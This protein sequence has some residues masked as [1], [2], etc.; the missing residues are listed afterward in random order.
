[1][2]VR[3]LESI[4]RPHSVAIIG[5]TP[6]AGAVGRLI[7]DNVRGSGFTG[8]IYPVN[9]RGAAVDGHAGFASIAAVPEPPDLAVIATPAD[10]VPGLIAEI[11]A[12]G[13]RGVVVI[14]AGFGEG[15]TADGENRRR[16]M[17]EAARPHLLRIVGPNCFG[18]IAPH[19]R[20]NASF[21]AATPQA[22]GVAFVTQSGAM[23]AAVMD[24]ATPRG[25]GFSAVVSVGDMTDVDFGD[26]LDWLSV[27]PATSAIL[28]YVEAI[29]HPRKFMSAARAAARAKPVIVIKSGRHGAAAKAATSHTGALAG[30]DAVYDAAFARAGVLRVRTIQQLFD[31]LALLAV[32]GPPKGERLAVVTNGGGAGVLAMDDL[33]DA[34]G[35]P[36]VLATDTIARLDRV[37]PAIWSR[38]NPV[39]IIG[40]ADAGR[41]TAAIAATL[42][43]PNVDAVAV[44]FCPTAV[45][46]ALA[47]AQAVAAI[48]R[49]KPILTAWLGEASVQQARAAL[50]A[51]GLPTF[52][53]PGEAID[54]FTNLVR[55]RKRREALMEVPPA[56]AAVPPDR[57]AAARRLIDHAASGWLPPATCRDLLGLYGIPINPI[58][59]AVTPDEAAAIAARLGRPVALKVRSPDVVHKSDVGGVVLDLESG[60][61]VRTAAAAMRERVLRALPAARFDGFTVEAMVRRPRAI[62]LFLG[63][64]VDATFGPVIAFG[65]GGTAVEVIRDQALGLPP[66]NLPLARAM[67]AETQVGRLLKGYRAEPP[68]DLDA[69]AAALVAVSQLV[70]DLPTVVD[71]DVNPLLADS[72]G[73]VA[74]DARVKIGVGT[75]ARLVISPYP[76]ELEGTM[77]LRSGDDVFVRP[78][79]P[80]DE[81]LIEELVRSLTPEDARFRF[82][83]P[84]R[85]LGH[86]SAA[87]LSQ[88]DYD[89]E[90][91]LMAFP[92]GENT[93]WGVVRMH[94]DP[95]GERA[96]FALTVASARQGLGLG[97]ALL[98][99]LIA[100]AKARGIGELWGLVLRDNARML[101]L[102][103][104]LGFETRP[105]QN[106]ANAVVC[107]R[108]LT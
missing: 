94:A 7:F 11:G 17:L 43:D 70:I 87:R 86:A 92:A 107:A 91:A 69:L 100:L 36:A 52:A 89:R 28:L 74:V 4:L 27:D 37:L 95:D 5:A 25:I 60:D 68:A 97:Y 14:T 79:R 1:V 108:A 58:F 26:L 76:S 55:F 104:E 71:I 18:V 73:I 31:T 84:L 16:A 32:S 82:F 101:K 67:I 99:R 63:L 106:D 51:D 9:P 21:A 35:V 33:L 13:T 78:I 62:E 61:A 46:D 65:R 59:P 29:T 66:L 34:G 49:N 80:E 75:P 72:D 47:V 64:T 96:E 23:M 20:L 88:I 77:R 10:A 93:P 105:T 6:R 30:S 22:G 3:H 19:S 2:S 12:K 98:A 102:C 24:W 41:Y 85:G 90:I 50:T 39:D 103:G 81:P 15:G 42:A 38:G 40:D 54:G 57:V 8:P 53:T 45:A 44:L 83:S 48:P 56:A